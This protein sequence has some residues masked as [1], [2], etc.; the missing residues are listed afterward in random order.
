[1]TIQ[2][3]TDKNIAGDEKLEAYVNTLVADKLARFREHITRI[4]IHLSDENGSKTG[5]QDKC[6][7]LEARLENRQPILVSSN[8]NTIE[9]AVSNSISKLL[10]SIETIIGKQRN[11]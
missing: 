8:E 11:H 5:E 3:N 7:K 6:C 1:M 2:F 10:A 4:E 9:K